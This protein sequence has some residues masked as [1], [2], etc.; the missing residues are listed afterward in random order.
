[1]GDTPAGIWVLP[2]SQPGKRLVSSQRKGNVSAVMSSAS[3]HKKR[4]P[5]VPRWI[6]R[7]DSPI[8]GR[9]V[10]AVRDIPCDT[11][12]VEYT[13]E[14]ITKAEAVQREEERLERQRQGGDDCVTIFDLNQRFDL[15]GRS[16]SN[17]ARLINHSCEPNCR[18]ETIRGHVWIIARRDIAAGEELT[19][20]YGFPYREWRFHPCACGA[21]SCV[22]FIVNKA[23]RWRV[24]RLLRGRKRAVVKG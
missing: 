22:G 24:R 15:D 12:V 4:Q 11:R 10:R 2:H 21:P 20:D 18:S 23:Q 3:T 6:R 19:F 7:Y 9:G 13:G 8:H 14:R 1:M 5:V 17:I 16:S